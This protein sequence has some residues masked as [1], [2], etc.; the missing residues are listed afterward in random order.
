M[1]YNGNSKHGST[2]ERAS[3][4]VRCV[5]YV[6]VSTDRQAEKQAGSL[7]TQQDRI[8]KYL[9]ARCRDGVSFELLEIYREEGRSAKNVNRPELQR[10]MQD[11]ARGDIQILV[12]TKLD[13]LTR[14]IQDF[15]HLWDMLKGQ[16]VELV[17]LDDSFDTTTPIGRAML[18][19]I[20]T[21]A[22]LER[23]TTSERTKGKM[24]WRAEQGFWNGSRPLGYDLDPNQKGILVPHPE[25]AGIVR[26]IFEKFAG[27]GSAGAVVKYL[28]SNGVTI[29][30]QKT[31]RGR[32]IPSR[33]FYKPTVLRILTNPVYVGRIAYAGRI[34]AGKHKALIDEGEFNQVQRRLEALSRTRRNMYAD[35][36]RV[37]VLQGILVCGGCGAQMTPKYCAG[38]GKR[39]YHYYQ[40]TTNCHIGSEACKM[41]YAPADAIENA[42][43]EV[44][45]RVAVDREGLQEI[46][47]VANEG[48]SQI[49]GKL[50]QEERSVR[51]RLNT[52]QS[53]LTN[54]VG[55]L[56]DGGLSK[57]AAIRE[58][59]ERLEVERSGLDGKLSEIRAELSAVETEVID[60][61][62]VRQSLQTFSEIVGIAKPEELRKVASLFI[63]Q[64]VLFGPDENGEGKVQV[65]FFES[66]YRR[67]V[68]ID[69]SPDPG[70]VTPS[71]IS[72]WSVLGGSP[73]RTLF[74]T[75]APG[76]AMG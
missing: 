29:P 64:V 73:N 50:R 5:G 42:V 34:F 58:E 11:L 45:K 4:T 3:G 31:K 27:L 32:V 14:S 40:C 57:V 18:N 51:A 61:V 19:I 26:S 12:V 20:L 76:T 70:G 66:P 56:K 48:S 41:K 23:E 13:R 53:Q 75:I 21:F 67:G 37:Y 62:T 30:E 63:E 28:F 1:Q 33:R 8:R 54:L 52:V 36:S 72:R 65:W 22:Q 71:S 16:N 49:V 59:T 25:E 55:V 60:S 39:L 6:R 46:V 74:G 2:R 69:G 9:E 17:S 43:V 47:R 35:R 15:Y 24:A 10:L 44:L 7:E 38:R 68:P